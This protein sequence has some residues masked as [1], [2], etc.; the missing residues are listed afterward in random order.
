LLHF[1][2]NDGKNDGI[3][4]LALAMTISFVLAA[5]IQS[6]L[7]SPAFHGDD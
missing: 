1:I 5:A 2:R 4:L 3:A 6:G 7:E